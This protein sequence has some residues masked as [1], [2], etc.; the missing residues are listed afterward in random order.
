M[1]QTASIQ[2]PYDYSVSNSTYERSSPVVVI[3]LVVRDR[4]AWS[5]LAALKQRRG[6]WILAV[7]LRAERVQARQVERL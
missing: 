7:E 2:W 3:I 6:E 5:R 4:R 1:K